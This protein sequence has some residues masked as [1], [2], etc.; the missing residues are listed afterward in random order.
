[1]GPVRQV[2]GESASL[3]AR[4][5]W[6]QHASTLLC[7]PRKEQPRPSFLR[8]IFLLL[9]LLLPSQRGFSQMLGKSMP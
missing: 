3:A 7:K 1:M 6:G 5:G 4:A 9:L 2:W 8:L